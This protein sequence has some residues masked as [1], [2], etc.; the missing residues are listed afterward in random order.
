M[1]SAVATRV[2]IV[3]LAALI[4]NLRH[5][6]LSINENNDTRFPSHNVIAVASIRPICPI[7]FLSTLT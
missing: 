6:V 5:P 1:T 7:I 4:V 2:V 3:G